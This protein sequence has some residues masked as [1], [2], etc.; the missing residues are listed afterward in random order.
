MNSSKNKLLLSYL[1]NIYSYNVDSRVLIFLLRAFYIKI[2]IIYILLFSPKAKHAICIHWWIRFSAQ[3]QTELAL[4]K[5][6][7]VGLP[8]W[9]GARVQPTGRPGRR[10]NPA[11]AVASLDGLRRCRLSLWQYPWET[12]AA[13]TPRSQPVSHQAWCY[14]YRSGSVGLVTW[15]CR[16]QCFTWRPLQKSDFQKNPQNYLDTELI[17]VIRNYLKEIEECVFYIHLSTLKENY[18]CSL[19]KKK[20]KHL[21]K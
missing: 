14:S 9:V 11:A 5:D 1:N 21:C 4:H 19:S 8:S 16:V 17:L 15:F 18:F 6:L 3:S 7:H 10:Q 12:L 2:F 13:N 20:K